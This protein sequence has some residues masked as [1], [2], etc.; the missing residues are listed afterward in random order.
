MSREGLPNTILPPQTTQS[1]TVKDVNFAEHLTPERQTV[2]S[3]CDSFRNVLTDIPG[4]TNLVK[5]KIKLTSSD[6]IRLKQYPIP[7]NTESIIREE[8][9]KMLQLNV[10]EPSSSPYSAPIVLARKKDRTNDFAST[11]ASLT[12][13]QCSMQNQCLIL[14]AFFPS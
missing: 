11:S 2:E 8:V 3:L 14:I 5:H 9:E 6:P 1:K 10:I 13:L 12:I 7:F 4:A